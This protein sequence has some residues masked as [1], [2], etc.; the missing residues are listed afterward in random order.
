MN[1][2]FT[3]PPES[4]DEL[5]L[6]LKKLNVLCTCIGKINEKCGDFSPC[7]LRDGKPVNIIFSS[8]FDHFKESK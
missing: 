1:F 7:F 6:R 2:V 3:I 4:K 8:G 5:E